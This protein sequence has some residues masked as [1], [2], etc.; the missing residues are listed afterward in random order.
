MPD[1][2]WR[3]RAAMITGFLSLVVWNLMMAW[4]IKALAP[5]GF[6]LA[7]LTVSLA[8]SLSLE[9]W[10]GTH[11]FHGFSSSKWG[12]ITFRVIILIVI[13]HL[14][15]G[16]EMSLWE[17]FLPTLNPF[18]KIAGAE[19]ATVVRATGYLLFAVGFL[20]EFSRRLAIRWQRSALAMIS[21]YITNG[22]V[23]IASS[24]VI[25]AAIVGVEWEGWLFPRV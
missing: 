16:L 13:S 18:M 21:W 19:L 12:K 10:M 20:F 5:V 2:R 25:L 14:L 9:G 4:R 22:T 3:F 7:V 1:L 17:E 15:A 6:G 11:R 23:C 8:A 24:F